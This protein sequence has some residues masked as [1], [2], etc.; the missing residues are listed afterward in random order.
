VIG[1]VFLT[2]VVFLRVD[3]LAWVF[4]RFALIFPVAIFCFAITA[5]LIP[6][7]FETCS[8]SLLDEKVSQ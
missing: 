8:E 3:A 1:L 2:V 6:W 4:L 7:I 5:S